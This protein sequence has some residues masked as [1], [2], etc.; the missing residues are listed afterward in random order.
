VFHPGTI[1]I[2]LK[3]VRHT[4]QSI[5]T[6]ETLDGLRFENVNELS[7][8]FVSTSAGECIW[9]ELARASFVKSQDTLIF[10]LRAKQVPASY[11]W[12]EVSGTGLRKY[13]TMAR[14]AAVLAAS[15]DA[16]AMLGTTLRV[17]FA[18]DE[19]QLE[20]ERENYPLL[21]WFA[22]GLRAQKVQYRLSYDSIQH[23][24]MVALNT[25]QTSAST[26]RARTSF[27]G[28]QAKLSRMTWSDKQWNPI[29]A[30]FLIAGE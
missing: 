5:A 20:V 22:L 6:A 27:S 11:P 18:N 9:D 1:L 4:A 15:R 7:G 14:P 8:E 2:D 23:T 3:G 17:C 16:H 21:I 10:R 13:V 25:N 12:M 26:E 19:G 28:G 24:R 30:G 29:S